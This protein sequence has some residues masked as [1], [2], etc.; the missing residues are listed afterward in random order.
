M[1]VHL[2]R[3]NKQHQS[4][5]HNFCL[6]SMEDLAFLV[7]VHSMPPG[8]SMSGAYMS[9]LND[10]FLRELHSLRVQ[11]SAK[12]ELV[13]CH[14]DVT[15]AFWYLV[16]PEA[17]QGGFRVQIDG[18]IYGFSCLPFGWQSS[19]LILS[20][21]VG[22]HFT[23]RPVLVLQYIDDFV[24]VGYGMNRYGTNRVRTAARAL[25]DALWRAG[26]IISIKSVLK[27]VPE[28]PW[29]GKNLVFLVPM[30]EGAGLDFLGR[31]VDSGSSVAPLQEACT[32]YMGRYVWALRPST[33]Y[34]P[35]LSGWWAHC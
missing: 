14:I 15:N 5:P 19:P 35:F 31:P 3:F 20:V 10:H 23:V 32:M 2:V 30:R 9:Y 6:P 18:Q 16:L 4:K 13:A 29:L 27:P 25:S 34:T 12:E 26:A 11:A 17:L 28:I 21:C 8:L 22:I 1:I 33:G 7:Q 24:V